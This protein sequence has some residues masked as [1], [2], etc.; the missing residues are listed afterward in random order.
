VVAIATSASAA[1]GRAPPAL[2]VACRQQVICRRDRPD[3]GSRLEMR[4]GIPASCKAS[5]R[6]SSADAGADDN[7]SSMFS[8]PVA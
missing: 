6:V 4:Q 3:F 7:H 2:L 5:P 1:S 8:V